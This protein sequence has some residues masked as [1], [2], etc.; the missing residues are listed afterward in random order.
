V[1][2]GVFLVGAIHGD[3][4]NAP[5]AVDFYEVCHIAGLLSE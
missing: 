3:T 2:Q 1:R 4:E 5:V